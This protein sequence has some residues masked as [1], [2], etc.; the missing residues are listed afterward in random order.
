MYMLRA[1]WQA[2]QPL[3]WLG[4]C[5]GTCVGCLPC[6]DKMGQ[7]IRL[8]SLTCSAWQGRC[9]DLPSAAAAGA[10]CVGRPPDQRAMLVHLARHRP[11]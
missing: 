8:A 3:N 5:T 6:M 2:D 7:Q 4:G 11:W 9:T 10:V 1:S